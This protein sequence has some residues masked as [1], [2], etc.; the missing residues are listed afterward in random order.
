M[1]PYPSYERDSTCISSTHIHIFLQLRNLTSIR[2][3]LNLNRHALRQLL[4]RHA[5]PRRL[6]RKVLLEHAV[7]LGKVRH[8]IEE[9]VDLDLF[10]QPHIDR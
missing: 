3:A 9:D 5:A 1:R 6:V 7:H 2:N 8:V 4:D 10:C